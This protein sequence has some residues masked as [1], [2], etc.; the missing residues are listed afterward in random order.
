MKPIYLYQPA[1]LLLQTYLF[2]KTETKYLQIVI[3]DRNP[4]VK[5]RMDKK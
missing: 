2:T 3:D 5:Y 4:L 1:R